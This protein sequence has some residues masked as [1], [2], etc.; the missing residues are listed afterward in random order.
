MATIDRRF[1]DVQSQIQDGFQTQIHDAIEKA[2]QNFFQSSDGVSGLRQV[3]GGTPSNAPTV[4]VFDAGP[5]HSNTA[6]TAS[7]SKVDRNQESRTDVA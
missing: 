3:S 2:L 4:L 7:T 5:T 1:K 6:A